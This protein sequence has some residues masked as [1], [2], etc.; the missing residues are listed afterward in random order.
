[1]GNTCCAH[2]RN[3][4]RVLEDE[5]SIDLGSDCI[6]IDPLEQNESGIFFFNE[7]NHEVNQSPLSSLLIQNPAFL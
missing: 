3:I 2:E 5:V 1:M 7:M 4:L 6:N